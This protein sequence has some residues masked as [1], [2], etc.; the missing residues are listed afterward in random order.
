MMLLL[1][2]SIK[3]KQIVD[4]VT[5]ATEDS[6]NQQQFSSAPRQHLI[7]HTLLPST[8]TPLKPK[9]PALVCHS[10]QASRKLL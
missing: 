7:F 2:S 5:E 3:G 10:K 9:P 4:K 6:R 8:Q 1:L